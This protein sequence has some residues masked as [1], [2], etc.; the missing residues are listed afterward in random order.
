MPVRTAGVPQVPR[1]VHEAG[2][3]PAL[4]CAAGGAA[5]HREDAAGARGGRWAVAC[6]GWFAV[7][8]GRICRRLLSTEAMLVTQSL[9]AWPPCTAA[10]HRW[11]SPDAASVSPWLA[12]EAGVPFFS[13]SASEFVEL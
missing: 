13:V 4:G 10:V 7:R 1:K 6:G 5:R 3:P 11:G 8:W 12:G 2:R 9:P